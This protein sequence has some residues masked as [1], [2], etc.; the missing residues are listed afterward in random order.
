MNDLHIKTQHTSPVSALCAALAVAGCSLIYPTYERPAAPVA[1]HFEGASASRWRRATAA[2]IAGK[3]DLENFLPRRPLKRLIALSL[4]N[5]RDLRVAVLTIEQARAQLQVRQADQLPTINVGVTGTRG[6][7]TSGAITSTYTAGLNVTAYE[8]DLLGRVRALSQAARRS[9][10]APKRPARRCRSGLIASVA[11]P[12]LSLLADDALLRVTRDTLASRQESLK[13][14][15]LKFGNEAAS[16]L[17]LSTAQ[18]L[19]WRAPRAAHAQATR[20]RA[21]D[22][23]N[24]LVLLVGQSLP[25]ICRRACPHWSGPTGRFAPSCAFR[26]A[27]PA[28]PISARPNRCCWPTTP[29]LAQRAQPSFRASA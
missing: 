14:M 20:Q 27:D 22:R 3:A 13:L 18:S 28:A 17:D 29:T 21:L 2:S 11:N 19:C 1:P 9:C 7:A 5:N 16:K 24:A 6:P 8:L 10:W 25:A 23:R 15:Q 26:L 4:E 12:Y